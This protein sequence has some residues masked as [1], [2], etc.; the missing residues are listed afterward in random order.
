M[1]A[2]APGADT[3]LFDLLSSLEPEVNLVAEAFAEEM[4]LGSTLDEIS[5]R[6]EATFMDCSRRCSLSLTSLDFWYRRRSSERSIYQ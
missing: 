3:V 2:R 1:G 5:L 6:S 4:L